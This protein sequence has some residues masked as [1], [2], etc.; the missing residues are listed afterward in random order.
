ML[1]VCDTFDY[2]DY[3]VYVKPGEDPRQKAETYQ[4]GENMQ[5]LM[6]CYSLSMSKEDQMKE[7]RA[8]HWD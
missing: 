8:F 6:E 2:D 3:P 1:V 4:R 7:H 5:R